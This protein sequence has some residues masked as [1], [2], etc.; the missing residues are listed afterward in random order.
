[1]NKR[2]IKPD[3]GEVAGAPAPLQAF[4]R[5]DGK[6]R[7]VPLDNASPWFVDAAALFEDPLWKGRALMQA[8]RYGEAAT[9]LAT[10]PG[11]EAAFARMSTPTP[12]GRS[13]PFLATATC[14]PAAAAR[15]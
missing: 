5:A 11:A 4:K 8:G 12:S 9:V 1:M 6:R 15:L 14:S 10:V 7:D 13:S 2:A 3:D